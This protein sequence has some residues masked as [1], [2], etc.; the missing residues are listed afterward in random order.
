MPNRCGPLGLPALLLIAGCSGS[1]V[2]L[3]ANG[4]PQ[5]SPDAPLTAEFSSIQSHVFTP[6]CTECH[7]GASA[8]LGLRLDAASAYAALV[9]APSVE[10]PGLKR[11]S[12]GDPAGSY[13]L[14]KIEGTA[15]VG[16]RMPLGETPL[17]QATIDI[18]RQ[19]IQD[20][21]KPPVAAATLGSATLLT[22]V[23]PM[24]NDVLHAA[25]AA[26]VIAAS[27]ELDTTLL[28]GYSVSLVRAGGDGGF[29][30]GNEVALTGLAIQL[31]S[32]NPTVFAVSVPADQWVADRYRLVVSGTGAFAVRD[33]AL[34]AIDG[35]GDGA[36][37]G[38]YVLQ[39]D[40]EATP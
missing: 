13:M 23:L 35:D 14:H 26:I 19:W 7:A 18:I 22:A 15:S 38:D 2:G 30:Q 11:V 39:F 8:P 6:I 4:R 25:P 9:N 17:P 27:A 29:I 37:G 33:R 1:G 24:Q 40:L 34:L 32:I 3:D 16:G 20:G 5:Q 10:S 12:P 36:P 21:A 31:R 28:N